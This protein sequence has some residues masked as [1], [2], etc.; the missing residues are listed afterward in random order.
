MTLFEG[1][2]VT[3]KFGGLTAVNSV[4][5]NIEKGE[6]RALIGPNGSGKTTFI[7]LISGVYQLTDGK[8]MFNGKEISNLKPYKITE[9][10]I[11][12]TFQNIRLFPELS[13]IQNVMVGRHTQ[14]K[15]GLWDSWLRTRK[16]RHE[17]EKNRQICFDFIQ[18]VGLDGKENFKA[19][20]LSY[21]QQRLVEIA[22]AL[23]AEPSLL[24]LDEPAA[25]MNSKEKME[26]MNLIRKINERGITILLIEH[27]MK[28]V[29]EV[30]NQISVLNFGRLI[31]E[32]TPKE[33]GNNSSVIE[34]YLGKGGVIYAGG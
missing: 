28:L 2:G 32:G 23:A 30:S 8:I 14:I 24:L 18:F 27:D 15:Y 22:R 25:G 6:I 7:N 3:K 11:S 26:L 5:L 29:M 34:A 4:E 33:I 1:K 12:R 31:A 21:G 16:E 13:V 19:K 20:N 10:G 17:E 9:T